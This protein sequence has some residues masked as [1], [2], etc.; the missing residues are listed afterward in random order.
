MNDPTRSAGW[1][2]RLLIC[3]LLLTAC[4]PRSATL[5]TRQ[6]PSNP[7]LLAFT[8]PTS[9]FDHLYL[10]DTSS[11]LPIR[12]M[13]LPGSQRCP[14]FSPDGTY[15]AFCSGEDSS[16]LY[17]ANADG[18]EPHPLTDQ[19]TTCGCSPDAPLAWS[20][21]G[22]WL[23]LPVTGNDASKTTYD[24]FAV[25]ADGQ[26]VINLTTSPQR[27]YGVLWDPDSR[28]LLFT[29]KLKDQADI[30][31]IDIRT[32]KITPLLSSPVT[33]SASDWS[34]DGTSLLYVADSGGGNFDIYLL[35][36]GSEQP[37]RLTDAPGSDTYPKGFPD[38]KRILFIS[39]RDGDNEIYSMNA[40][41]S[42]QVNLTSNPGALDIWASLSLD[43][44][45]IIYLTASNNQ[46]DS[47]LM[48]ADGSGRK[49]M[50]DTLGIPATISWKP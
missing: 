32:R 16:Q 43:G 12:L 30:Y 19:I 18:T 39:S 24:L 25:S 23:A 29:G 10:F 49:K 6:P 15:I 3:L 48:N 47:W 35:E 20:P 38:G 37:T 46:W 34:P 31:R 26:K 36:K 33:G 27:Y 7:G 4:A 44:K 40:D 21:D 5:P 45:Q 13:D 2:L 8:S 22:Q 42:G 28:S 17:L 1:Y 41:G 50:T 11:T 9:G 14:A